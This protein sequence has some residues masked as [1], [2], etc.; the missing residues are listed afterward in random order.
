MGVNFLQKEENFV[1]IDYL[2]LEEEM[3]EMAGGEIF[4]KEV[5]KNPIWRS[6]GCED[7]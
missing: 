5:R 6:G 2:V 7:F 1:S 3:P 4:S